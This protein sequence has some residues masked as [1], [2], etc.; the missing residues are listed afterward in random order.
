MVQEGAIPDPFAKD[1]AFD[2]GAQP[3]SGDRARNQRRASAQF[4]LADRRC[5]SPERSCRDF[6][7]RAV[8]LGAAGDVA[9][10]ASDLAAAIALD[11]TDPMVN[12]AALRW[13]DPQTSGLAA[14]RLIDSECA[15]PSLLAE[16]ISVRLAAGAP[17]V[18]RLLPNGPD[19]AGWVAWTGEAPVR[20]RA[21]SAGAAVEATLVANPSH[22]LRGEGY[23]VADFAFADVEAATLL[24]GET[25]LVECVGPAFGAPGA[26]PEGALQ[27]ASATVIVPVY[28]GFE[29]TRACLESLWAQEE[30]SAAI[31]LVDDACPDARI[32]G[33]LA[34]A[35]RRPGV[36]LLSNE[37]N[38][39]FARSVNRAL[40]LSGRGDVV[41][42]NADAALP[43]G[44]LARLA[45]LAKS[46]P[47]IGTITPLSNN[48]QYTSYP[49]PNVANP[50]P[51][52]EE[53]EALDG[54]AQ[55]ANGSRLV[56]LPT[57]VGFCLYITR[58]CLD[59]VGALPEFYGR[60]YYEDVEFCLAARERGYR[61]VCATGM[62]VGHS[63]SASFGE[64]KLALTVKN[65]S[66]LEDRFPGRAHEGD[67]FARADPLRAARA[68]IDERA[69]PAG[70]RALLAAAPGRAAWRAERRARETESGGLPA[71]VI[72]AV[73]P[74]ARRVELSRPGEGAPA[75]LTFD[76][77]SGGLRRLADYLR[78]LAAEVV[79]IFDALS[80]PE[81]L[82]DVLI[83]LGTPVELHDVDLWTF[84]GEPK[85][86]H[87]SCAFLA[88]LGP[89]ESCAADPDG[90]P[91]VAAA[92]K[93]RDLSAARILAAA[94]AVH[95]SDRMGAAFAERLFGSKAMAWRREPRPRSKRAT[96]EKLGVLAP[97]ASAANDR[98]IARLARRLASRAAGEPDIIVLGACLNESEVTATGV[99]FVTG[100]VAPEE[101][102]RLIDLHDIG[103]LALLDRAGFFDLV[104]DLAD[105]V[106]T[107]KAYFDS[108]LGAFEARPGDL[109]LDPRICDAKAAQAIASWMGLET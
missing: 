92:R 13:T 33:L 14:A 25:T 32:R 90:D 9:G 104:D 55:R 18:W 31:V 24:I 75:T 22:R 77:D 29:E 85:P 103:R 56:D 91:D 41:L 66:T 59:A 11:P 65:L 68:A 21:I 79:E 74:G 15:Q 6:L 60:G 63:G 102:E 64:L 34:D 53:I 39:G 50:M 89:C 10:V 107:P 100:P 5:R 88:E 81:T 30:A 26:A 108:S 49:K 86:R 46:D 3:F 69:P 72:L 51:H 48:S 42:L 84:R 7:A 17:A 94:R 58:A 101:Y 98:L 96:G 99:A 47:R 105:A 83:A 12:R 93:P 20:A 78:S 8:A 19:L 23:A 95:S 109:A 44:A 27:P 54:L 43:R 87:G 16:A 71:A 82:I 4:R 28:G 57:G 76:L 45:A 1:G 52:P 61:N 37:I 106:E 38:L 70:A 35:A 36:T 80:I 2:S 73:A 67:A 97:F 40:A 62:F